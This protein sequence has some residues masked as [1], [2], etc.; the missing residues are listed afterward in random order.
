MTAHE[1]EAATQDVLV[2]REGGIVTITLNRPERRNAVRLTGWEALAAA[3]RAAGADET[4]RVIIVRGAGDAAFCAGADIGEFPTVRADRAGAARYHEAVAGAFAILGA[5]PQPTIAMIHGHCIGGGC[6]LAV[7]CDIR[8]AD[9]DARFAIPAARLGVV[10]G[11]T[12][13]RALRDLIGTAAAKDLLLTGRTLSAA[14]ALRVGLVGDVVPR[15]EL[16]GATAALAERIAGYSPV[17]LAAIKDLLGRLGRGESAAD[18][19]AAHAAHVGRAFAA[20]NRDAG[21]RA[22]LDRPSRA[23]GGDRRGSGQG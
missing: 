2:A 18:L 22:F 5:V 8:I 3:V 1:T 4:T 7:A 23:A 6:E 15:A 11:V 20:P 16:A 12:E 9:E 13:L 10:L 17:A 21:V 19:A 14:E